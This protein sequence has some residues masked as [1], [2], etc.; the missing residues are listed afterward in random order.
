M[1]RL[2]IIDL[3]M[4]HVHFVSARKHLVIC[5]LGE[6]DRQYHTYSVA[7]T[8]CTNGMNAESKHFCAIYSVRSPTDCVASVM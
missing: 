3:K 2:R 6:G 8:A 1:L 5:I 7:V 4:W